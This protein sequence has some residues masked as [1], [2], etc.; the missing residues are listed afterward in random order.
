MLFHPTCPNST[1]RAV[2]RYLLEEVNV[3]VKEEAKSGSKFIDFKAPLQS[4][5]NIC[6]AVAEG[7][8][9]FLG[10]CRAC[11]TDVITAD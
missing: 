6:K 10:C 8:G 3:S 5:L 7:E 11:F 1:G 4:R 2:L 9:K